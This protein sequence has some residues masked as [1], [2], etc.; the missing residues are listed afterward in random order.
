MKKLLPLMILLIL[1]SAFSQAREGVLSYKAKV[2][3]SKIEFSSKPV[4]VS[5]YGS[6]YPR[7]NHKAY[8]E[9]TPY[10]ELL[11]NSSVLSRMKCVPGTFELHTIVND[12]INMYDS[13]V[14]RIDYS[15]V[16]VK[17]YKEVQSY[18]YFKGYKY[19]AS[20]SGNVAYLISKTT[21][22]SYVVS[23]CK[24]KNV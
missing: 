11:F 21:P 19:F 10:Y 8:A 5:K 17:G 7:D 18:N 13:L 16:K 9:R 15:L 20:P 23:I 12:S 14:S 1:S 3:I 24:V 6:F 22:F 2:V 4:L